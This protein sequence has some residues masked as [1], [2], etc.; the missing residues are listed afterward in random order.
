LFVRWKCSLVDSENLREQ[1]PRL[2]DHAA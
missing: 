2:I 1:L